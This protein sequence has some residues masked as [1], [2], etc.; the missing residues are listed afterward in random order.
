MRKICDKESLSLNSWRSLQFQCSDVIVFDNHVLGI[1]AKRVCENRSIRQK[2]FLPYCYLL[3]VGPFVWD[4]SRKLRIVL[5]NP[6]YG[7]FWLI[8]WFIHVGCADIILVLE[9]YFRDSFRSPFV[10]SRLL[11]VSCVRR[12]GPKKSPRFCWMLTFKHDEQFRY[13]TA[14]GYAQDVRTKTWRGNVHSCMWNIH[15]HQPCQQL[16]RNIYTLCSGYNINWISC[17]CKRSHWEQFD[18][19]VI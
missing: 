13:R 4:K 14:F 8:F 10:T 6:D 17:V 16:S 7:I 5:G 2:V 19:K 9:A 11:V 3:S 1:F 12:R 15:F 18:P